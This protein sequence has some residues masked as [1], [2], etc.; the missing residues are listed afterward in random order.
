MSSKDI[1]SKQYLEIPEHFADAFNYYVYNGR[2]VIKPD[3]L[4]EVDPEEMVFF[5][6]AD[7]STALKRLRDLMRW[8][9]IP[10]LTV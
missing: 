10:S 3:D 6:G 4:A 8:C 7:K 5:S 9:I 1:K 2:Q